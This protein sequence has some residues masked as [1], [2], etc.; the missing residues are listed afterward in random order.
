MRLRMCEADQQQYGGPEWLDPAAAVEALNDLDYDQLVAI[1]DQITAELGEDKTLPWVAAQ[2]TYR[3]RQSSSIGVLRVRLWLALR[4]WMMQTHGTAVKLA[5]FKP[6]V[7]AAEVE[8]QT[9]DADP[10]SDGPDSSTSTTADT[11]A[12]PPSIEVSIPG[13]DANSE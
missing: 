12:S 3:T 4:Q 5:D 1:E 11:P 8:Y 10:P 6:H 9:P 7:L 13:P 2:L